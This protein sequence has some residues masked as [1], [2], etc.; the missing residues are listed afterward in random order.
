[1]QH[2]RIVKIEKSGYLAALFLFM[3]PPMRLRISI[4]VLM[5]CA[6]PQ[7]MAMD[8]ARADSRGNA[9][10]AG[11]PA[12]QR[13]PAPAAHP[14][15]SSPSPAGE[16]ASERVIAQLDELIELGLPALA[17]AI[18]DQ[19]QQRLRPYSADWYVFERKRV[20][21]LALLERWQ[22]IIART[23]RLLQAESREA[24][25]LPQVSDWFAT[26]Q[27]IAL[28]RSGMAEPALAV[29]RRLLWSPAYYPRSA[30]FALWRQLVVRAY[31]IDDNIRDAETAMLRYDFDYR[32]G[33]FALTPDW[34]QTRAGVLFRAGRYR[35]VMALLKDTEDSELRALYQLARLRADPG[36]AKKLS[37]Q[38]SKT[39][40]GTI[41]SRG[42]QWA[43]RY[44]RY[45]IARLGGQRKAIIDA[46]RALLSVSP[47]RHLLQQIVS[48]DAD[49]LWR[50]Y[51]S[52][53]TMLGNRYHLL[54][55][56]DEAWFNRAMALKSRDS[57]KT[58]ALL[59]TL[60]LQ[61]RDLQHRQ[62]AH[63]EL[64]SIL[65]RRNNSLDLITQMYLH[66]TFIDSLKVLPVSLRLALID[67]AL[68][69]KRISDAAR[70]MQSLE[71]VPEDEDAF[72]WQLRKARVLIL[73][74][75]YAAGEK[76]LA[77]LFAD[78]P[79]LD[80]EQIDHLFQVLFDL[81]LVQQHKT[82]LRYFRQL[83]AQPL[84]F[85][86][87]RELYFWMAESHYALADHARAAMLYLRSAR[88]QDGGMSD[89]W[90]LAARLKA[91]EAL[92][93]AGLY[94]D[95]ETVYRQLLKAT[96]NVS[97]RALI[98]QELQQIHL[99]RN[100]RRASADKPETR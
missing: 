94:D 98:E 36:Y 89:Q 91:A 83:S 39:G 41:V 14:P 9:G 25:L 90:A 77:Q 35:Q 29:L 30:M 79:Q 68:S 46:L 22:E 4:L 67:H 75:E 82:A 73:E 96:G 72:V 49:E 54:N 23:D 44:L 81:Q 69:K 6:T 88:A 12:P 51:R 24:R 21:V 61:S 45:E 32:D 55:G 76:V 37:A 13:A 66:S 20:S 97:R 59:A 47:A 74:G 56:D 42:E 38:L 1:M 57:L 27:A 65:Q 63:A 92:V 87:R 17:L 78:V 93:K 85:Q 60:A 2:S 50:Q 19:Q 84:D 18:I 70:L 8:K 80:G 34:L 52:L 5:L 3:M 100:A 48:V 86:T 71:Q 7:A 95:A 40:R 26:Q 64:V 99:L 28:I 31:L 10:A 62:A 33:D 58:V 16:A 43:R 53:G 15:S 11:K